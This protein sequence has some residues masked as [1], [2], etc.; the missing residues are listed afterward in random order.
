MIIVDLHGI[1][2]EH[3]LSIAHSLFSLVDSQSSPVKSS[4]VKLVVHNWFLIHSISYTVSYPSHTTGLIKIV[5][6]LLFS[7]S[8]YFCCSFISSFIWN[9]ICGHCLRLPFRA[10][11]QS[12]YEYCSTTWAHCCCTD[13]EKIKKNR[14][15][16][17]QNSSN[18]FTLDA[19]FF[20]ILF[21]RWAFE[22]SKWNKCGNAKE[23]NTKR[24]F[25]THT[26]IICNNILCIIWNSPQ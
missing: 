9:E 25:H 20:L 26:Y 3:H 14:R 22:K 7:V 5:I 19:H 1:S 11:N 21:V 6:F 2:S 16:K 15:I 10:H 12:Q 24:F 17:F 13:R 8:S 23:I 18:S 4:Q